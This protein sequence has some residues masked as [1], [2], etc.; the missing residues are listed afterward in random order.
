MF[1]RLLIS[2]LIV[3]FS[4]QNAFALFGTRPMGMGGAFTAVSD[5]ANAAYWNPAGLALNPEVSLTGSGLANNRN[6][7][8]GDNVS[9]LK[10]CYE[11]EMSPFEWIAGIGIASVLAFQG[12]HYLSEQGI[13]KKGWGRE[14]EK[15]A[16]E[17]SMAVQVKGTEEVISFRQEAKE[18]I[19]EAA[20]EAFA[21]TKQIAKEAVKETIRETR[22]YYMTPWHSP[23][24]HHDYYHPH[25]WEPKIERP[26]TKAQF[27][28]GISWIIDYNAK[29][30]IDQNL[31]LY[32]LSLASG[33]EQRI[34]VGGNINIYN[35]ERISSGI[36]GLGADLDLG[37]VA[38]P[39][40]YI[41]LGLATKGILTTDIKWQ[42]TET[43]RN[44][45]LV[46]AG[47]A[48]KPIYSLTLAADVHN[49]FNQNGKNATMHYGT[50][51]VL[52]PGLLARAG[53]DDGNKTAGLSAAI[54]NLILDYAILGGSYNR[55]QMIGATWRF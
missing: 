7:W 26:V 29:P 14:G 46:N 45:M 38:K 22:H 51:A 50:E 25:Y 52:L 39:V 34:A 49:V 13:L 8:V 17:E 16:R 30:Q 10:L 11:A 27:A 5:D 23:W 55:T 3:I 37:V 20:K 53:L 43:T 44:E 41:S 33:F 2:S 15:T 42:T 47:I 40:E 1:K 12:A 36:K 6:T 18:A 48:I 28:L 9:N 24:Y 54:G 35:L 21:G 32:T 4:F 31:N 19:K